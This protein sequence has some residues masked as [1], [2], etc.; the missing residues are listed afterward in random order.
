MAEATAIK[1]ALAAFA[2][3]LAC[4]AFANAA[5]ADDPRDVMLVDQRG[6]KF[7]L[8]DFAREPTFVTF[9]ASRCNDACPIANLMFFGLERT[10][11]KEGL[12]ARLLT[13]TLDPSY[14]TPF[15]MSGLAH[16]FG[17]RP[18]T[19]RFASGDPRLVLRV[20]DAFGVVARTGKSGV[21]EVHSSFVYLLDGHGRLV[22]TLLLSTALAD[23]AVR[24]LDAIRPLQRG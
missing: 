12:H 6:A 2:V 20:M 21:P 18:D 15:V 23:D 16:R 10:L 24:A 17:A 7:N 4:C 22:R 9:V 14:D 8:R 19:W 13:V 5:R 1:F 11:H 3:V